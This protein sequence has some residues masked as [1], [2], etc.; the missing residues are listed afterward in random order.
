MD[1][2]IATYDRRQA[3]GKSSYLKDAIMLPTINCDIR[4]LPLISLLTSALFINVAKVSCNFEGLFENILLQDT[5]I[6]QSLYLITR[7]SYFKRKVSYYKIL[8]LISASR[9]YLHYTKIR[10]YLSL[11][12]THK[13]YRNNSSLNMI[14]C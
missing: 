3:K 8:L 12:T 10:Q 14:N 2:I 7:Y 1:F 6:E 13:Q 5:A 4:R 11:M 9:Y